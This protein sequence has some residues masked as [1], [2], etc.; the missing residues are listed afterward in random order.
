M[1]AVV[2]RAVRAQVLVEGHPVGRIE[3]GLVV[4]LGVGVEDK[5]ADADYLAD[6]TAHL[7]IFEDRE[8][9]M[10][11]SIIDTGGELLVVSQFTLYGDC[12]RGRRPSFTCA[13]APEA[14]D[15]LYLRFIERLRGL[16]LE[17][18]TGTFRAQMV[19]EVCNDGPVTMLL[20]SQ[21]QF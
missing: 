14:A 17:V 4:F 9:K 1:R 18:E 12:R 7:R 19:V 8:G 13:A 5:E 2:Q 6:K 11:R 21:R 10:N 20:D 16:G 3:K 15:R